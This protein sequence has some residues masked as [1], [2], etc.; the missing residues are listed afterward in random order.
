MSEQP[1]DSK[2]V[3]GGPGIT[4]GG[5]VS[6]SDILGQVS[7]GKNIYQINSKNPVQESF[8]IAPIQ[9]QALTEPF[10][11]IPVMQEI[12]SH[13][14]NSSNSQGIL[15][16]TAIQGLGGI[17]KTTLAK[18]IA[19][20]KEVQ[21]YFSNGILWVTLGQEPD[22]LSLLNGWIKELRDSQSNHT[23]VETAS[24]HLITLLYEKRIL[25]VVDDA[26]NSRD[27]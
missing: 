27:V 1:V 23:T 9:V 8:H 22:K 13:L 18:I 2:N 25:L 14:L 26:W 21:D 16:I 5:N 3:M 19:H 12:K 10:V 7:I 17:G 24:N 20:D 11:E 15:A 4:A 6:I